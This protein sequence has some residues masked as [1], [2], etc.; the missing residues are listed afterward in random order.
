MEHIEIKDDKNIWSMK[1][2][3]TGKPYL[4]ASPPVSLL[5]QVT[6]KLSVKICII[7]LFHLSWCECKKQAQQSENTCLPWDK[8]LM[9]KVLLFELFQKL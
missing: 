1:G 8:T 5:L 3:Y 7:L 2:K 6:L 9:L 4:P